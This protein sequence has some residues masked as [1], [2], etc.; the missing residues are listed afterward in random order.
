[1]HKPTITKPPKEGYTFKKIMYIGIFF[2]IAFL[3]CLL[4][5][6]YPSNGN[7][8]GDLAI[9]TL[10]TLGI[11]INVITYYALQK[12]YLLRSDLIK[13]LLT[14]SFLGLIISAPY[15]L[16]SSPLQLINNADKYMIF[17]FMTIILFPTT[18]LPTGIFLY[19]IGEK[20]HNKIWSQEKTIR[21]IESYTK[22]YLRILIIYLTINLILIFGTPPL[23]AIDFI[24]DLYAH[25]FIEYKKSKN[26]LKFIKRIYSKE[27]KE[28]ILFRPKSKY[29]Y[30]YEYTV[31]YG[32]DKETKIM[33][34]YVSPYGYPYHTN[35]T[36]RETIH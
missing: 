2:C 34:F 14:F 21:N 1:M 27:D 17:V 25:Q 20:I 22:K 26:T 12:D 15:I 32:S 36:T 5:I 30:F 35:Y 33:S 28:Y 13:I 24:A 18:I 31:D 4:I 8:Y 11:P 3:S 6:G 16:T 9:F 23:F 7:I 19:K 10:Y 29:Q